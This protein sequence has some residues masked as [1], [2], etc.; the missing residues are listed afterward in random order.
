M[1]LHGREDPLGL[2]AWRARWSRILTAL[3]VSSSRAETSA[4]SSS[5]MSR[6]R[7]SQTGRLEAIYCATLTMEGEGEERALTFDHVATIIAPST[8][9][10]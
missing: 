10:S 2:H 4:V 1:A 8:R 3:G 5:S 7:D 9:E 6:W